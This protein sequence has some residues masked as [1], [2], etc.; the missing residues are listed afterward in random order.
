V[1]NSAPGVQRMRQVVFGLKRWAVLLL[2][3][4]ASCLLAVPRAAA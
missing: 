2:L 1:R 3:V 4:T